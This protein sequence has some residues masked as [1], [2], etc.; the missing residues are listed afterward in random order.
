MDKENRKEI[1]SLAM[2]IFK[3]EEY[4]VI[5]T[6]L[7]EEKYTELRYFISDELELR[8]VLAHIIDDEALREEIKLCN[9]IENVVINYYVEHY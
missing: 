4:E 8:E 2:R 9:R 3:D 6:L 1:L 5:Q 7:K